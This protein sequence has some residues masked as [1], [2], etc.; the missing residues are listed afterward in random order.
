MTI[1]EVASIKESQVEV[2]EE[3]EVS[4]SPSPMRRFEINDA[5]P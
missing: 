4:H 3:D 2:Q 5:S 1:D